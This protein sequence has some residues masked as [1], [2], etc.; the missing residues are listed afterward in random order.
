[1][2]P[3]KCEMKRFFLVVMLAICTVPVQAG[4]RQNILNGGMTMSEEYDSNRYETEDDRVEYWQTVLA[5]SLS[6]LSSGNHDILDLT[7][8][9]EITYDHQREINDIEHNLSLTLDREFSDRLRGSLFNEFSYFDYDEVDV[10]AAGDLVGQFIRADDYV[11]A[12]VVRIL[13]PELGEY[14]EEDYTYVLSELEERYDRASPVQQ[15]QVDRLL[16]PS[17]RGRRRHSTNDLTF[18]LEYEFAEDSNVSVGY[19][20]STLNDHSADI[21][22]R[23]DHQPCFSISYRFNPQWRAELAYEYIASNFKGDQV[24]ERGHDSEFRLDFDLTPHDLLYLSYDF[25]SLEYRGEGDDHVEQ[26]SGLGWEHDFD[27]QTSLNVYLG[28]SYE[29]RDIS[30]DERGYEANATFSREMQHARWTLEADGGYDEY[31]E[32]GDWDDLRRY[33][34]LRGDLI[35]DLRENLSSDFSLLYERNISWSGTGGGRTEITDNDYEASLGITYT[36]LRWYSVSVTYAFHRLNTDGPVRD[37]YDDH[38][39]FLEFSAM[40]ELFRW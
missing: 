6:L 1:M 21:A 16:L 31:K 38:Q 24:D 36:F 14:T 10:G 13:F 29:K 8:E 27:T 22:E 20:L 12:E 34:T 3:S 2:K 40:K 19:T 25:S 7:Y 11:Q 23:T 33:V 39:V 32:G 35:F 28:G 37:D 5:P 18:E 4:A 9:P 17:D 15:A 30:G 26:E